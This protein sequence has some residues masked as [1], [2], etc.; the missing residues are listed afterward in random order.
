ML[1]IFGFRKQWSGID[2]APQTGFAT[3]NWS[4]GNDYL[5]RN[6]L[7]LPDHGDDPMSRNYMQNYTASPAHHGV[8]VTVVSDKAGP[9]A[10]TDVNLT[11]A[12]H[13]KLTDRIN[14]ST[15]IAAGISR[16]TLDMDQL[17]LQDPNDP[18][19]KNTI[20]G[21]TKPDLSIGVW[22]YGASF[23]AGASMQQ[24]IPQKLSFT[25]DP[26]YTTGKEKSHYFITGGYRFF[27]QEDIA[28]VPSVMLKYV[29]NTPVSVDLNC[30]FSY[31]DKFWLGGS[32][33]KDDSF[34]A[35]A[36]VNIN[37][38]VNVTYSYDFTTSE[39]NTATGGSH[40]IVLGIQLNKLYGIA[41]R[42]PIW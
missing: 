22:V 4:L 11:Y 18:A 27:V 7:S 19:L 32:Y 8:G 35:L 29:S 30:K 31:K 16:I 41:S 6:P 20:V 13:L 33:R 40:E 36:G 25:T 42:I 37:K 26:N 2:N 17:N 10:R 1:L 12:Y 24:V 15:G 28:A 9:L 14:M 34:S 21:Q 23:F 5:W 3:I 39:L 38:L